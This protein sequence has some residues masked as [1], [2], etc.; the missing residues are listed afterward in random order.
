MP[1][2]IIHKDGA[3]NIFS[4]VVDAPIFA[5]ALTLEQLRDW[6]GAE[7]GRQGLEELP[8]RLERAVANGTSSMIGHTL[9]DHIRANRA[10]E[11]EAELSHDDFIRQYI[12]LRANA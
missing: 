9:E 1:Q 10:G 11:N 6:Y 7:Y 8:P 4:T 12:T 2:Y 3:Y 5:E